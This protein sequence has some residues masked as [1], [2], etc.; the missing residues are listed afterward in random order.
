MNSSLAACLSGEEFRDQEV[1]A[2]GVWAWCFSHVHIRVWGEL[3]LKREA[4][5]ALLF[6]LSER[7]KILL[8]KHL[9]YVTDTEDQSSVGRV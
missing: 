3:S 7:S 6:E 2:S 1:E 8:L 9:A 5:W 4:A